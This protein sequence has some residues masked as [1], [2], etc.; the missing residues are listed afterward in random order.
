[1]GDLEARADCIE[2]RLKNIQATMLT[3]SN[4]YP[5]WLLANLVSYGLMAG[6]VVA[7]NAVGAFG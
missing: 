2:A 3:K 4:I 6:A 7:L 1:M 5:T